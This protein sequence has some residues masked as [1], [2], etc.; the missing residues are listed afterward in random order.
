MR[1]RI[2]GA[3]DEVV[4]RHRAE[5]NAEI[6]AQIDAS[7]RAEVDRIVTEIRQVE[8]RDRRD[9]IAAAER[10]AVASTA[11]FVQRE[12]REARSFPHPVATLEHALALA[13][14]GGLAL[15]FGV[16]TGS[17]LTIIAAARDGG[18]YGFDSFDGLPENWRAGF[19]TGAFAVARPPDV[20][21]A[22]LV[23]GLFADTLPGFLAA[24]PGPVDLLHLDA[25]LHSS[26][27]CVLDA[28]GPRLHPGSVVVFD[29]FFNYP[30]W[31]QHEARAWREYAEAHGVA[32]RYEAFTHD[33]EQ[34]VVRLV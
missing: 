30:G 31:E 5:Q 22:E 26:T 6:R 11:R 25:D 13:P 19:D 1:A 3:V 16:F 9:T 23:V 18:V 20:P 2:V 24:H 4:S 29:E 15:E 21:G 8:I 32:F 34:V 17:T 27:A 7:V 28:V 12:M 10:E 33:N 14:T